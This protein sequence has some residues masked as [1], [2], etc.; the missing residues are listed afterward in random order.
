MRGVMNTTR[1]KAKATISGNRG[2]HKSLF[3]LSRR[4]T[5]SDQ[6]LK[7]EG[8]QLSA[9]WILAPAVQEGTTRDW[10]AVAHFL[11]YE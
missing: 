9:L 3:S 4:E 10:P 8:Q 1:W 5:L 7:P 6:D 11:M 2:R